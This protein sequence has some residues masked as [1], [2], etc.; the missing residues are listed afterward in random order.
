MS[1][2]LTFSLASLVLIMA[3]GLVF[4][5]APVLAHDAEQTGDP[6]TVGPH[7]THP[8]KVETQA[9]NAD[10]D[11]VPPTPAVL[12]IPIHGVHPTVEVSLKAGDTVSGTEA[13]VTSGA[14]VV[15]LVVQF[16]IPIHA[17]TTDGTETA[18]ETDLTAVGSLLAL[19]DFT[20]AIRDNS[21]TSAL[22]GALVTGA[23]PLAELASISGT[24]QIGLGTIVRTEAMGMGS[25]FEV[26]LT[27]PADAIPNGVA[28]D[29]EEKLHLIIRVN[30][31]AGYGLQEGLASDDGLGDVTVPG[32]ES[33]ASMV[34]T[35]TL[36]DALTEEVEAMLPTVES[37]TSALVSG[38]VVFTI[39]F[40]EALAEAGLGM[41]TV[42][43]FEITGADPMEDPVLAVDADDSTMYTLTVTPVDADTSVMISLRANSVEDAAG[44]VLVTVDDMDETLESVMAVYD[45][46]APTLTI[47]SAAGTGKV[48]FTIS[49]DEELEGFTIAD[50][51]VSNAAPLKVAD[52]VE[53]ESTTA[54]PLPD[55]VEARYMLTVTPTDATMPNVLNL[56]AGSV[57]DA[58]A[59]MVDGMRVTFTPGDTDDDDDDTPA[60][61][62]ATS[63]AAGNYLVF[64]PANFD[65]TTLPSTVVRAAAVAD[66][67]NL[68]TFFDGGGTIDLVVTGGAKHGAIITEIMLAEDLGNVGGSGTARPEAAQWIEIYNDTAAAIAVSAISFNF[69]KFDGTAPA[70][71]TGQTDRVS[72]VVEPDAWNLGT[73]F[74]GAVSGQ[75]SE[76]TDGDTIVTK[77]FNSL[78]RVYK[79]G[80]ALQ[81][82]TAADQILDGWKAGTWALTS[83]SRVYL[84]GRVG[85]PG[86]E[87]RPTVFS[88]A[89]YKA[90][91]MAITF[92]EIANRMDD[93]N[94][95]IELKGPKDTNL[96]HHKISIVTGYD[97][98][99]NTGTET[100]IHAF[101]TDNDDW[102]IP[103]GDLLLLTDQDP[104]NSEI[105]ADLEKGVPKPVRY[106]IVTLAALPNDGNFLLVLRAKDGV[107]VD[108]AGHLA[109]LDDDDPYTLMWPLASNV[110]AAKPGRISALNKLA[111][112]NVYKRARAIQ[113]YLAIKDDG[114]EPAFEG[115]GFSGIGYDRL[116]SAGNKEHHGTPGYP[117][118]SQIG[119]GT[120][121]T[122][123]VIISEI[124]FAD[125]TDAF[126]QW[127]EI[128]NMSATNGVDLHNWRLYIV[129][130]SEN[131]DGSAFAGNLVDEVWLRNMKI[132][133]NQ[134]A[135]IVTRS[136]PRHTTNLPV[137]R[138]LN[139]RYDKPLLSSKGFSLRLE[140][141]S[142]EGEVAKRQAGDEVG[143]LAEVGAGAG[144]AGRQAFLEPAWALPAGVDDSG[145][146][147]VRISIARLTSVKR[148]SMGTDEAAWISSSDDARPYGTATYYGTSTDVG[149]P[150]HT[151][152]GV[153]P[154]SL[155]KFRPERL[156]DGTIV[157][158][159]ITESEL[160]NAGFNILR[161]ETRNG[162][163]TKMNTSLIKGQG[164][165]SERTTYS[166]PDTSAKPNVVYYYQIQDVS[167]D[168]KVT[169]L[170][171]SRLKGHVSAAG[172]LTTTWGELKALQ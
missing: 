108:V 105:A 57:M 129:N 116:V 4:G 152:G 32:G 81:D 47:T 62:T 158:R 36:V 156:D 12:A 46:T 44:N 88:P 146:R 110:G 97:K 85:T 82:V 166:F 58:S 137:H 80:K 107:I 37:I 106:R 59:N 140:A 165:T 45:K 23:T 122:A 102:K 151:A 65:T 161:S 79:D 30:Q 38:N 72:N 118:G 96:R 139:V 149:S 132:P 60:P 94:E 84:S 112:G 52:L 104:V 39:T 63:V 90:P 61:S 168:G 89:V 134:T 164:T 74:A 34:E 133:P 103:A 93:S 111:G 95:W 136:A 11:T 148:T 86:S 26:P 28:M 75:T 66:F 49:S 77:T 10:A 113:G 135:L 124:M 78:R 163:F 7:T 147:A 51:S 83:T 8:V 50:L 155:S 71:P 154:V 29:H 109:G 16:S 157:V 125:G 9:A 141:K 22:T 48:I 40:S 68:K 171:Q 150:G 142:N 31:G 144:Q 98:A 3:L 169:T 91:T 128:H 119:D 100:T 115:A 127:I 123:N 5:T 53:V 19:G 160:N 27:I 167:L 42:S 20:V 143:N 2:R 117:N 25:K 145:P 54:V 126:P 130:H 55:G 64:V 162:D 92:N 121:A 153:L 172:K 70:A 114:K 67:P 73:A 24:D 101:P 69:T 56:A 159:W 33:Q 99:T 41:L 43:D 87:N 14:A 35:F 18:V 13:I 170:R 120:A 15:T 138:I 17:T 21:G 6:A 76:N 1:N 131:A